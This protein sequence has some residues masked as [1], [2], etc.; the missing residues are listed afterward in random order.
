MLKRI[1]V[2]NPS[3]KAADIKRNHPSVFRNL[4]DRYLHNCLS[5]RLRMPCRRS[6]KKPLLTE[7]IKQARLKFCEQYINWGYEECSKV[8]CSDEST[9]CTIRSRSKSIRRP[10][11]SNRYDPKYIVKTVKHPDSVMVWGC[12]SA[13]G[14]SDLFFLPKNLMMNQKVYLGV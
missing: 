9:F 13:K 10:M 11:G 6:T 7:K 1:I 14:P 8:M 3:F 12:F 4:S 5:K 2:Q